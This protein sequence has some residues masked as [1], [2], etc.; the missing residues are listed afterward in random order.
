MDSPDARAQGDT[1]RRTSSTRDWWLWAALPAIAALA[2]LWWLATPAPAPLL[3]LQ[4]SELS[5][6]ALL[7]AQPGPTGPPAG[8]APAVTDVTGHDEEAASTVAASVAAYD[9]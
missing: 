3:N 6:A 9:R 2:G 4:T 7:R 5:Q 8:R 1:R